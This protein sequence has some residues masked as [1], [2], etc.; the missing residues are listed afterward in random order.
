MCSWWI[1]ILYFYLNSLYY[2]NLFRLRRF[3]SSYF[4]KI[5]MKRVK[6]KHFGNYRSKIIYLQNHGDRNGT[7]VNYGD[8]YTIIYIYIYIYIKNQNHHSC[9]VSASGSRDGWHQWMRVYSMGHVHSNPEESTR[10][11][12]ITLLFFFF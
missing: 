3:S 10:F 9:G 11:I 6:F 2:I 5:F 8:K 1:I 7:L 4:I 12:L